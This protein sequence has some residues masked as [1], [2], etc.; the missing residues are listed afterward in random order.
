M[1]Y[2]ITLD[3]VDL[4][5]NNTDICL[6]KNDVKSHSFKFSITED[7]AAKDYSGYTAIIKF[8]R[9][10]RLRVV[11]NELKPEENVIT[12]EVQNNITSVAGYV[13]G[14]ISLY[15][16]DV[17][18]TTNM[19]RFRVADEIDTDGN[20]AGDDRLPILDEML[21]QVMEIYHQWEAGIVD[22]KAIIGREFVEEHIA[23]MKNPHKVSAQQVG[24][25]RIT[26]SDIEDLF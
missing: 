19:F 16:D 24:V 23:D 8:A 9:S 7:G 26:N 25:E 22:W 2:S 11:S 3:T 1:I 20:V 14:E 12:Y 18:V 4:T 15:K 6:K 17:R 10:D 21:N 5:Q 13:K